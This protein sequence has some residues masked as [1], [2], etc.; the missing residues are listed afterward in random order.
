L[1]PDFDWRQAGLDLD[2]LWDGGTATLNY[3]YGRRT[4]PDTTERDHRE[5]DLG[6]SALWRVS[7]RFGLDGWASAARRLADRDSAF[8]DRFWQADAEARAT[9]RAGETF[10]CGVRSRVRGVAYDEPT[11]TFFDGRFYRQAVFARWAGPTTVLE[12]RPEIEFARTPDFGGL[13]PGA[14][15]EDRQAVAGEEYDELALRVEY[16]RFAAAGWW[17]LA[18][19]AGRRDYLDAATSAEDL[20]ARSDFWFVELMAF[21][22]RRF[23]MVT[24]RAT[25]DLRWEE[26]TVAADDVRSLSVAGELR[27]PLY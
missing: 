8:G 11:P 7:A 17:T 19:G 6:A 2:R 21:A 26:H 25:A 9:W 24:L 22:D 15:T 13:P 10:E 27:V 16:E 12:L 1:F 23:G 18:P 4:F 14:S 5:H 20:S 3:A